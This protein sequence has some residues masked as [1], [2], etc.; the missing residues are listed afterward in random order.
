MPS[1]GLD[2]ITSDETESL[3]RPESKATATSSHTADHTEKTVVQNN[4][5]SLGDDANSTDHLER[6]LTLGLEHQG[7]YQ[8]V[9]LTGPDD[10][11]S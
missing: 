10:P 1:P 7:E 2:V 9:K 4:V 3:D 8:I 11:T 6:H 5:R